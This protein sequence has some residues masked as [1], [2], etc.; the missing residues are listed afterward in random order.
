[1]NLNLF[2]CLYVSETNQFQGEF[3]N[4]TKEKFY[5]DRVLKQKKKYSLTLLRNFAEKFQYHIS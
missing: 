2:I 5:Y 4:F 1:M 3:D